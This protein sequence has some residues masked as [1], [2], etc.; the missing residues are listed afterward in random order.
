LLFTGC[1][2]QKLYTHAHLEMKGKYTGWKTM[3]VSYCHVCA[4]SYSSPVFCHMLLPLKCSC[5]LSYYEGPHPSKDQKNFGMK[6]SD[7]SELSETQPLETPY[8][9]FLSVH[10]KRK[11]I[12][13]Q[14]ISHLYI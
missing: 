1:T 11:G 3:G 12:A 4:Y 10:L 7:L 5:R 8:P 9:C 14:D 6:K 2:G 13:V